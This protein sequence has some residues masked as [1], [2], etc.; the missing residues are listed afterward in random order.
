MLPDKQHDEQARQDFVASLRAHLAARVM[1]GNAMLYTSRLE[2]EFVKEHGRPPSDFREVKNIMTNND[3]YQFWSAMQRRSQELMWDAVIDPTERELDVLIERYQRLAKDKP[4]GGSLRLDP[5][6][7]IPR[8]HTAADIH[9]QP[10]GYHTDFTEDDVTAGAVYEG[11]LPIYIGGA[12]GPDSDFLGRIL[13]NFA[14]AT[15]PDLEVNKILDLGCGVGNCT[16]PWQAVYNDAELYATDVAAP[17]LRYG[18]ARA[19]LYGI[20]VHFSQQNAESTDFEDNSFDLVVSHIM[21]HETSKTALLNIFK[22]SLRILRPGG[23]MLHLEIPRGTE[24]FEQ[25]MFQWETYNNNET[26]ARFM[27]EIDLPSVA[28]KAGFSKEKTKMIGA[29]SGFSQ[30][31]K[32]YTDSQFLWPILYGE[33]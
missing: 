12:L 3:Y 27:T 10:G 1:P 26:F 24:P 31:Q 2:P 17:C 25:F 8:Y 15:F 29:D 28:I 21:L 22:E 30:E 18:H 23:L 6:L 20:P 5:E 19:E 13:A 7:E 32:N 11:G 14:N 16:L 4:A 33:K 9:I